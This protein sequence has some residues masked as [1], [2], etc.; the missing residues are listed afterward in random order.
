MRIEHYDFGRIVINGKEFRKDVLIDSNKKI[1][2]WWRK[3]GHEVCIEDVKE[4]LESDAEIFII[5]TGYYGYVKVLPEV[6]NEFEKRKIKVISEKTEK[7]CEIFNELS[8][9]K[10]LCAGFHLTC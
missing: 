6:L 8:A 7:A 10:K 4:L 3:R 9:S 5:G 1:S 2:S